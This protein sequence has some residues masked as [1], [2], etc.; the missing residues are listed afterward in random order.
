MAPEDHMAT[1]TPVSPYPAVRS[2]AQSELVIARKKDLLVRLVQCQQKPN[3]LTGLALVV[4]TV[5]LLASELEYECALKVRA[6]A[7]IARDRAVR[8]VCGR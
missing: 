6:L 2:R 1:L 3:L 7:T 8:R 4:E 5:D